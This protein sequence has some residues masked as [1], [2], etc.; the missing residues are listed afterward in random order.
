MPEAASSS[1]SPANEPQLQAI[2]LELL[3]EHPLN[4]NLMYEGQVEKLA[5]N[6]E[7]EERYPPLVA[8]PHPERPGEWQLLDGH[9]RLEALRRL[10]HANAVVFP[11]PCDGHCTVPEGCPQ[12][13]PAFDVAS[14]GNR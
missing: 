14:Q 7:R 6:I 10:G 1:S 8:R 3:H 9:Q 11:W 13:H 12:G 2:A 5:R 4:A